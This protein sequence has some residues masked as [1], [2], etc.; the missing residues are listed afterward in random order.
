MIFG[1]DRA[2]YYRR[3]RRLDCAAAG[4]LSDPVTVYGNT[5][6]GKVRRGNFIFLTWQG[7]IALARARLRDR[8]LVVK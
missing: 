4:Q 6:R 5:S 1:S 7:T 3:V 2:R 8:K